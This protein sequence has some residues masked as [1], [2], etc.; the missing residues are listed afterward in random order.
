MNPLHFAY[1]SAASAL[2]L[3]A[4]FGGTFALLFCERFVHARTQHR[5]GPGRGGKTDYFQVWTD[6]LKVRAKA[7]DARQVLPA[8]FQVA[9]AAWVLLPPAYLLVLFSPIVPNVHAQLEIPLLLLLPLLAT[10]I[11]AVFMHATQDTK[12]R[13]EWRK[14]LMLR[15]TGASILY[16]SV[17][18]VGLRGGFASL[19][20]VSDLQERFPYHAIFSSPGLLLCGLGAFAAVFLFA[21]ESPAGSRSDLSLRRSLHYLLFYVNKMWVFCLLCFWVFLFLG[22]A[23]TIAAKAAFPFKLAAT[24]FF[25]TLLQVSLPRARSV[26]A[27]GITARWLLRMCLVGLL[28]EALWVGVLG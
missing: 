6:F 21:A 12:E 28:L 19:E 15:L 8:R 18:A 22:G 23:G 7:G 4:L 16:L 24:V 25:F 17:V 11:E 13:Y 9:I 1:L 2:T 27:A 3:V 14:H 20:A 26:D 10:G 5:D